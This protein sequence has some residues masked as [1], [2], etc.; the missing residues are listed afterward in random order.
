[1]SRAKTAATPTVAEAAAEFI[2][3]YAKSRN[4]SWAETDRIFKRYVLP[5]WGDR[6]RV[7]C[8]RQLP[9]RCAGIRIGRSASCSQSGIDAIVRYRPVSP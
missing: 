6:L 2:E 4:K 3:R 5:A 7:A 8:F 9:G 1:M